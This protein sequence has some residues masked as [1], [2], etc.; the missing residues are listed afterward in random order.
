MTRVKICGITT[1]AD[2]LAAVE[3]GTNALGFVFAKSPRRITTERAR[4]IVENT[5]PFVAAVGVFVD[6]PAERVMEIAL[7]CRLDT[8]QFHGRESPEYCHGFDRKVIKAFRVQDGSSVAQ[9]ADYDVDAYLLDSP[10]GGGSGKKFEWNLIKGIKGRIILAGGLTPGNVRE[11]IM[12]VRPYGVDVS[13]GVERS[14]GR[15]D[16][17]RMQEFIKNVR[18]C[19]RKD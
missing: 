3:Y 9:M 10:A 19:D 15:K 17:R 6:E 18:Q 12:K 11:A 2:A 16:H 7:L 13:T 4:Q 1:A 5:P 14:P 8:L